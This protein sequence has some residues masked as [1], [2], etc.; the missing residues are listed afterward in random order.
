MAFAKWKQLWRIAPCFAASHILKNGR[1]EIHAEA[2]YGC[3]YFSAEQTK[4]EADAISARGLQEI[5]RAWQRGDLY[6]QLWL[7]L[8][9]AGRIAP[10]PIEARASMRAALAAE[11]CAG[12]DRSAGEPQ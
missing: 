9:H 1:C 2:P 11:E 12:E 6:A 10:S 4:E 5:A 7:M 8:Y 3:A